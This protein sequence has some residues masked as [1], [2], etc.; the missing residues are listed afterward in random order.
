[1]SFQLARRGRTYH[2]RVDDMQIIPESLY[3]PEWS[4]PRGVRAWEHAIS[5]K[6]PIKFMQLCVTWAPEMNKVR[7]VARDCPVLRNS[8][9]VDKIASGYSYSYCLSGRFEFVREEIN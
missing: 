6:G 8:G 3:S 1:M 7:G 9:R 5:A 4:P 2:S